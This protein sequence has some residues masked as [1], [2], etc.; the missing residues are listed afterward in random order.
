MAF[1]ESL[2]TAR[3]FTSAARQYRFVVLV[4]RANTDLTVASGG[5]LV[6]HLQILA[7]FSL[8]VGANQAQSFQSLTFAEIF[9]LACLHKSLVS[10]EFNPLSANEAPVVLD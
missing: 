6:A 1:V 5:E 9:D 4:C 10:V 3:R 7:K 2:H 8:S